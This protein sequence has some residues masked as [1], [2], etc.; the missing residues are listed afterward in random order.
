[1]KPYWQYGK[2]LSFKQLNSVLGET[3]RTSQLLNNPQAFVPGRATR[4][5]KV[6]C[7]YCFLNPGTY[8][9]VYQ[10]Y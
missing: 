9:M 2:S 10:S 8:S 3:L 1:M 6:W 7:A 5:S 4:H